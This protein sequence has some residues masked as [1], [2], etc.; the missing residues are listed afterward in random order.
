MFA[1]AR[2]VA[3]MAPPRS[4]IARGLFAGLAC[5]ALAVGDVAFAADEQAMI[6]FAD[7]LFA[8]GFNEEAADEYRA[9]LKEFPEGKHRLGALYRLGEAETALGRYEGAIEAFD[10]AVA[11]GPGGEF[12]LRSRLRKGAVLIKLGRQDDAVKV[13]GPLIGEEAPEGIVGEALY[14]LGKAH[15][16]A[17]RA[18]SAV[19]AL[20]RLVR[21]HASNPF[22]PM[23]RYQLAFAYVAQG[24]LEKAAVEFSEVAGMEG[25]GDPLRMESHYRAAESYDKLGWFDAAVSAYER[26]EGDYPDSV[27]AHRARYG[28]SWALYE[29]GN[30]EAAMA[31]AEEFAAQ[32]PDSQYRPGTLYLLGNCFQQQERYDNALGTFQELRASFPE[33]EFALRTQYKVAWVHYLKGDRASAKREVDGFLGSAKTTGLE[34]DAL[35]LQGT[36]LYEEQAFSE[37]CDVFQRVYASF[38][39]SEFASDAVFKHGDCLKRLG[40]HMEAAEALGDFADRYPDHSRAI[41]AHLRAGDAYFALESYSEAVTR[42]ERAL[43]GVSGGPAHEEGLYRLAIAQYNRGKYVESTDVF[44]KLLES[45]ADGKY[46]PEANLRTGDYWL[47]EGGDPM[48][49]I[50]YF[51]S[52]HVGATDG[53]YAG[54]ALK[55]LALARYESKDFDGAAESF[56]RVM[57]AWRG[58][59]L[60]EKTYAWVGQH[61]FDREDWGKA[62]VAFEALLGHVPDYPNPE[63]V[64]YKMAECAENAGRSD[65]A[66]ERYEAVVVAAPASMTALDSKYRMARLYEAGGSMEA[67]LPLY[68]EGANAN[69]GE[70][71]ALS[72][73]RLGEIYEKREEYQAAAKHFM[74]VAILFFHPELS[75]ESLWR[76]GQCFEKGQD[77]E[78]AMKTYAEVLEEYP[79]SAQASLA[80]ARLD[81]LS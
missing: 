7:G 70:T 4:R 72:R 42:Y 41:E 79:D 3:G 61:L 58:V 52:A 73:F 1:Q 43:A 44:G 71:A 27:Y 26:L 37:A 53:P 69:N 40:R 25:A 39:S 77:F 55:G 47:R 64:L 81:E 24:D 15:A 50:P 12:A 8:R 18:A 48:K 30:V 20:S 68:E 13:L 38:P 23:G 2:P 10:Q 54:H 28:H 36:L 66:V 78:Q 76:A 14:F 57:T 60:N 74:R 29:A 80:Q 6:D 5:L 17:G 9:Y 67:A 46:A 11:G 49:A 62:L 34:G 63:R 56:L 19:S 32:Y 59:G 51:E 35:F 45:Y 33:S 75:P 21:E 31:A 16:E 65:E 22:V